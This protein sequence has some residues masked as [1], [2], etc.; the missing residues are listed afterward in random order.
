MSVLH[1]DCF[2]ENIQLIEINIENNCH[3]SVLCST[4][5]NVPHIFL[6]SIVFLR[7]SPF[8]NYF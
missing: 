8:D 7:I 1:T 2:E 5:I 6:K 3:I 4:D